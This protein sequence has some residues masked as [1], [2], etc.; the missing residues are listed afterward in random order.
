MTTGNDV[1]EIL[2]NR[3]I[4]YLHHANSLPTSLSLLKLKGLASRSFVEE[5][6][7]PQTSQYTDS[8]DKSLGVW[9]DIF[10]DTIDIHKRASNANLY[11]PILFQID[12]TI[13]KGVSLALFTKSNPS[14][15]STNTPLEHR[16]F[17]TTRELEQGLDI[18]NF[19][20][21]LTLRTSNG[22]LHFKDFLKYIIIDDP[23]SIAAPSS[24]YTK[25]HEAI[26]KLT[27]TPISRR[28]CSS[29]CKCKS[30]YSDDNFRNK[31]FSLC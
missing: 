28:H 10:V 14:K 24:E 25:A 20:Q 27:M 29:N 1:Y 15:W 23:V 17:S 6:R 31:M 7:L 21:M 16:Y 26:N 8:S 13:L 4:T 22:L 30:R 18:G 19:D 3:G 9:G 12:T 11:G 2:R 5:S